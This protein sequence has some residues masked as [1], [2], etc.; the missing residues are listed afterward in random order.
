MMFREMI[1]RG[2]ANME[3]TPLAAECSAD[4]ELRMLPGASVMW[5]GHTPH[6][7]EKCRDPGKSDDDCVLGWST[8]PVS[9]RQLGRDI[10]VG[11]G[12]ALLISS[13]DKARVES[14][15]SKTTMVTLKIPRAA[16]KA[17]VRGLE[18]TFMQ[19]VPTET[20]ALRLLKSYLATIHADQAAADIE[21][22]RAMVLHICDLV[23]LALGATRDGAELA[24]DRGLRAARLDAM[25]KHALER[26]GDPSLSVHDIAR[27]QGVSARYVQQLFERE[28]ATF[29]SFLLASRLALAHRRLGDPGSMP[30]P[31][32]AI[33]ADCGFGDLSYFNQCF[34]RRY[35]ETPSDVRNRARRQTD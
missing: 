17:Q 9:F 28:G 18:D 29:S 32:S 27:R 25:K 30:L 2:V 24:G 14:P 7:F 21:L 16:L 8:A 13:A 15:S 26:L 22:Q 33:A 4:L 31:I 5:G 1:G 20:D 12:P 11:A 3:I 23:A 34:R 35:G 6:R 19:P 10:T